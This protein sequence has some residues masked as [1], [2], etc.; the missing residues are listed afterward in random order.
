[1]TAIAPPIACVGLTKRFGNIEAVVDLDLVV[2]L[3]S[4][5]GFL[6]PNGAGK[7]T[8]IRLLAGL[9]RPT[10][11]QALLWGLP[12]N[13]AEARRRLG[14]MPSDPSFAAGLSGDANLE[15]LSRLQGAAPVDRAWACE[16]LDLT[17]EDLARPVRE[18]SGG[19]AQ[20]LGVVQAL[21]HRPGLVILDEPA[22]RLDPLA[23]RGFEQLI[24]GIRDRGDAVF[25]SSHTLSEV[26]DV[27]D[28]V[29]MVRAGRL[30][31]VR[32]VQELRAAQGRR[33]RITYRV[34]PPGAPPAGLEDAQLDGRVLTA[35]LRAGR[36][37][38]LRALIAD[39]DVVD[40]LVEE[41]SLEE[42]FVGL[43]AQ[44]DAG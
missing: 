16:L 29:A 39:P 38:L 4:I 12:A 22:N 17:P 19:M 20:K 5:T 10:A 36:V 37:D 9:T 44:A 30:L 40:V 8:V 41:L 1:M 42:T 2:P 34:A 6:G 28:R 27:C 26:Q 3:G 24:G 23:H 11:G 31:D 43:Y 14:Y 35:R 21:Q 13:Q 15:L 7:T 33:V 18:Y 25:L 32:G